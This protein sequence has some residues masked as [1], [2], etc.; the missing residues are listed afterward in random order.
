[1]AP[2]MEPLA[3]GTIQGLANQTMIMAR[4]GTARAIADSFAP[5][6]GLDLIMACALGFASILWFEAFKAVQRYRQARERTA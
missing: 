5:I 2:V 1:M 3:R 4:E 6:R